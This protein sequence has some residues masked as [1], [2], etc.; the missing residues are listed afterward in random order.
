LDAINAASEL[1]I[2]DDMLTDNTAKLT[3][4]IHNLPQLLERKKILDNHTSIATGTLKIF[5][6]PHNYSLP[7]F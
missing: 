5:I 6:I 1:I 7:L 3:S 2:S 4:A